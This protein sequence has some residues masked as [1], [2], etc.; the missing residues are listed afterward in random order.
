MRWFFNIRLFISSVSKESR[1]FIKEENIEGICKDIDEGSIPLDD[2]E[3]LLIL[4]FVI[5]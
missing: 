3:P 1:G 2:K 4:N 5:G